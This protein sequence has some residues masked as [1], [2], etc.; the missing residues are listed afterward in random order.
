[1][2]ELGIHAVFLRSLV[3]VSILSFAAGCS[4]RKTAVNKIGDA[5]AGGGS[6]YA[7]DNDPELIKAAVPF[8]LKLMESLL[9]ESPRHQGLLLAAASGFT[10][11][12][13]AFVQQE[14][15]ELED[16]DFAGAQAMRSRARRLF[17]RARD[18]GLR[19]MEARHRNFSEQLR[20]DPKR[21][22]QAARREDVPFLYWTSAAWASAIS[23]LKDSPDL[24]GDI[25]IVE[26]MM[27]RA[28]EL[29]EDWDFGAVH[30]FL[31]SYEMSRQG[32]EGDP[33]VRSRKHFERAMQLSAGQ[34]AGPLVTYA[35]S[36]SVQKQEVAE[37]RSLLNQAL[38]VDP[39]AR[40]EWRLANLIMQ[41]RARWLLSKT[42]E[43]FLLPEKN[44]TE[45]KEY[46]HEVPR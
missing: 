19:G 11:F 38:A 35:E 31:I 3:L 8:S 22:V 36:V 17:L 14:A 37:F 23:V 2:A 29:Q 33:A 16:K 26:A 39:D 45:F 9:A 44:K 7:S 21:A 4:I 46:K 20:K 5:L 24:I 30:S 27:D 18:Y 1:M 40:P 10:Q 42:D 25:G 43:L 34:M 41:R 32:V 6:T 15:D 13:F 28:L 12:A